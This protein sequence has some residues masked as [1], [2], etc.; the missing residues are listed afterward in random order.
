[1]GREI[2]DRVGNICLL[3]DDSVFVLHLG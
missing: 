3:A 2:N 1:M